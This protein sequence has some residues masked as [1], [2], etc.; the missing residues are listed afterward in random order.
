MHRPEHGSNFVLIVG[1]KLDGYRLQTVIRSVYTSA[2]KVHFGEMMS[3][4]LTFDLLTSK[5]NHLRRQLH[6]SCKFGIIP[7]V[8]CK[9]S[10]C[11]QTFR[12]L[13]TQ[14]IPLRFCYERTIVHTSHSRA[15]RYATRGCGSRLWLS[16]KVQKCQ[17]IHIIILQSL[18]LY[19]E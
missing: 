17:I 9:I 12:V 14:A 13:Y 2:G 6:L 5:F 11:S 7:Q 3:A 8:V 19:I 4:T 15:T 16:R 18:C 10:S 1:P